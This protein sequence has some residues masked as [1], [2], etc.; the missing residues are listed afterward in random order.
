MIKDLINNAQGDKTNYEFAKLIGVGPSS[1]SDWRSGRVIPSPRSVFKIA[2]ALKMEDKEMLALLQWT[3]LQKSK[4]DPSKKSRRLDA[5]DMKLIQAIE[6]EHGTLVKCP[7]EDPLLIR[8]RKRMGI[9]ENWRPSYN[10]KKIEGLRRRFKM[11]NQELSLA[12]GY[13]KQWYTNFYR[14]G[15]FKAHHAKRMA[16]YFGLEMAYFEG[17]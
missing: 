17:D 12:L 16:D 3:E 13:S 1:I 9:G 6:Y 10:K 4:S 2:R 11:S 14:S 8:L 5:Y 15:K 7:E